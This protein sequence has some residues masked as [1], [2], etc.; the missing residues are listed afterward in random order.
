MST[1]PNRKKVYTA[2]IRWRIVYQ[3]ITLGLCFTDIAKNLNIVQHTRLT[4]NLNLQVK[5]N[6]LHMIQDQI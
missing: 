3:Q 1:E 2:D 6:Q 4:I 5:Y